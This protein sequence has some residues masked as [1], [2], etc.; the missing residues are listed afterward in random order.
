MRIL[1]FLLLISISINASAETLK[2]G[3]LVDKHLQNVADL[4]SIGKHLTQELGEEKYDSYEIIT[5][6]Y[7]DIDNFVKIINRRKVDIVLDTLFS[8]AYIAK[9]ANMEPV[10]LIGRTGTVFIKGLLLVR[11][12]SGYASLKDLDGK[13]I[14]VPNKHTTT[15]YH[16]IK[17][18]I[19]SIG[20]KMIEVDSPESKVAK[21]NIGY[22]VT[23]DKKKAVNL[24]YLK[25]TAG[26]ATCS[27]TWT[28]ENHI[29]AFTKENLIA[30]HETTS[31]PGLFL[32]IRKDMPTETKNDIIN[33]LLNVSCDSI[34][35]S[36][37][38][39]CNISSFHKIGFDWQA[40][41]QN[42][43]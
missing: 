26:V 33:T 23:N 34:K 4:A 41:L 8:A 7:S 6:Q 36:P 32:L 37:I 24:T 3:K 43:N 15:S 1:L 22:F 20:L 11:K 9:N 28:G 12:D 31:V 35:N 13:V 21:G 16:L 30:I 29:P 27:A 17:K 2:I 39:N 14:A 42:I 40:L 5:E 38:H 19:E 18:D 25:K 10:L